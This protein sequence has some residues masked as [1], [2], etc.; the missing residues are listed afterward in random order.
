M[1]IENAQT[2]SAYPGLL[3]TKGLNR[4]LKE[5]DLMESP[6]V[7]TKRLLWRLK[8]LSKTVE[9]GRRFF[10]H[11]SE[12]LD[13]FMSDDF[14]DLFNLDKGTPEEQV[15]K[16]TRFMELKE[17]V[18]R[19]FIKDKAELPSILTNGNDQVVS[20]DLVFCNEER[21]NEVKQVHDSE[22]EDNDLLENNNLDEADSHPAEGSCTSELKEVVPQ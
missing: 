18:K 22:Y 17:D 5:M 16:Q 6:L 11:C 4:N 8:A 14:P 1:E 12:V 7:Q 3:A 9:T 13:N 2:T 15:I 21:S 10:P 20:G 19:A